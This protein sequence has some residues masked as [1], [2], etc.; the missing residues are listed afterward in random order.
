M[1]EPKSKID[2]K[3]FYTIS[4]IGKGSY[5]KVLLVKKKDNGHHYALK[6][7]KKNAV[8]LKSQ[9][10]HV[11]TERNILAKLNH[12]FI[13][14]L[15]GAFQSPR[16]L[17][18]LLEYCP[19]GELFNLLQRTRRLT[20]QQTVFFA[21]QIVLAIDHLHTNKIIY[22]DLKPENVLIDSE[23]YLKIADF[24]LSKLGTDK[25]KSIC[26]TPE[27]LAP[28]VLKGKEY[29][30]TVDWWGLG[31]LIYE[32]LTGMPPFYTSNRSVLF[33]KIR[34]SA[35][36]FPEY[37][38]KASADLILRLLVKDPDKRLGV[39]GVDEIKNHFWFEN[40]DWQLL[41][42]KKY[43]SFCKPQIGK[44]FGLKYFDNEFTNMDVE[45]PVRSNEDGVK[46]YEDF[47]WE[48]G[49]NNGGG[50]GSGIWNKGLGE[51]VEE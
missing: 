1:Q 50:S 21:A 51:I 14:R 5:A 20:E 37:I 48:E 28:E 15:F 47:S 12:P 25:A 33:D 26:G 40:V 43:E 38:S 4:V 19:G 10:T 17:Y 44:D 9:Q 29:G 46:R 8:E 41:E 30:Y 18:F 6:V 3:S 36:L 32:M 27:Y 34:K 13:V 45:S 16:K 42:E 22:R 2:I 31:S 23:G 7:L 35:P 39:N 49:N 24:G 11:K